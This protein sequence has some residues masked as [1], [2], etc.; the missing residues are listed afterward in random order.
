[1]EDV[2]FLEIPSEMKEII[3][4]Y[5][6]SKDLEPLNY[7]IK[8]NTLNWGQV[9]QHRFGKYRKINYEE[10]ILLVDLTTFFYSGNFS[11]AEITEDD[12]DMW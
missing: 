4:S 1:M 5:L 8:V 2:Y 9:Y 11:F 3:V 6:E 10:Y 7:V 12:Y